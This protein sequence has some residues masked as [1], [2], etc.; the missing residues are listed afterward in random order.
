MKYELH[1]SGNDQAP[2]LIPTPFREDEWHL[3]LGP[4]QLDSQGSYVTEIN[5]IGDLVK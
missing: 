2:V 4:R 1:K 3:V 5:S